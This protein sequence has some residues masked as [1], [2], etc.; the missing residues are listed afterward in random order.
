MILTNYSGFSCIFFSLH[1]RISL[2]GVN[3]IRKTPAGM[4]CPTASSEEFV[5]VEDNAYTE[6]IKAD[7][8]IFEFVQS[9]KNI[10]DADSKDENEMNDETPVPT[11][12]EMRNITKSMRS[13]LDAHSDGKMNR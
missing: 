13:Y 4:N 7:K 3:K 9:S 6:P 8:D 10:I 11:S 12:S 5:A 2:L 1:E